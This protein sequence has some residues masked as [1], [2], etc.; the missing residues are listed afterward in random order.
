MCGVLCFYFVLE[1]EVAGWL[2]G[3]GFVILG[4]GP[5]NFPVGPRLQIRWDAPGSS[6]IMR[7]WGPP[8]VP[9]LF[10]ALREY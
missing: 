4:P 7:I 10:S 6:H 8:Y 5:R 1:L 9:F 2:R 3:T